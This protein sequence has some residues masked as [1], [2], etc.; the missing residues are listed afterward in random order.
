MLQAGD[1]GPRPSNN[2]LDGEVII[3]NRF[4]WN[5]TEQASWTHALFTGYNINVVI[6][7]NYLLNTPNGIQR[8]SNGMTDSDGVVAYN[9]LKNPR[10]GIAVKGINGIKIYNNTFYSDKTPAQTWRGLV[11]ICINT[12]AGLNALATGTKVFNNIFYTR[13]KIFNIKIHEEEC[14]ENFESDY[15]VFWCEAGEPI[16]EIAGKSKTF[17]QWQALGYDLHSVI[18]NP[19]FIDLIDFVPNKRLDYGKNLGS[20]LGVGL[21][22]DAKWSKTNP[23]TTSQNGAWQVGARVFEREEDIDTIDLPLNST[24]IFPN[25]A[26]EF[27]Y[28]LLTDMDMQ[29]RNMKIFD[30][31]GFIIMESSIEYGLNGILLPEK[32]ASGLYSVTLE[33]DAI[34]RSVK[35]IIILD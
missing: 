33:A 28:I 31:K 25:P 34:G 17:S 1:E 21:A 27:F 6:K 12:D 5:G 20:E 23:Q 15:N 35:K 7:Y 13:N 19:D 2:N 4:V 11:D 29:Y 8:K 24:L 18:I 26:K 32:L 3:G 14:L 16:F 22:I 30:S 9:I 10:L